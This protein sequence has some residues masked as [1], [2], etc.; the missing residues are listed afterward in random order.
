MNPLAI[1]TGVVIA[2]S[3]S[4]AAFIYL[5]SSANERYTDFKSA[6]EQA[7]SQV[8][9]DNQRDIDAA[10]AN[11]AEVARIYN[12]VADRVRADYQSRLA[13]LR[14]EAG[15][16][17]TATRVAESAAGTDGRP[18]DAGSA[19]TAPAAAGYAHA[20]Q[21]LEADCA[22]TTLRFVWLRDWVKRVCK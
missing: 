7:Q 22:V 13:G 10:V 12:G 9:A 1:L 17:A 16:C 15:R 5:W 8:A 3:I 6:V 19:E 20:C 11:T 4:N 2:L 18:A 14:R 21:R